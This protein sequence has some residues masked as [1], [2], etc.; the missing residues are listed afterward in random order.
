MAQIDDV[1]EQL[2]E[3]TA[4]FN[5]FIKN[6][7]SITEFTEQNPPEDAT[8]IAGT[9]NGNN[10]KLSVG[11]LKPNYTAGTNIEI[12]NDVISTVNSPS[13]DYTDLNVLLNPPEYKAGRKWFDGKNWNYYDNIPGTSLQLAKEMVLPVR[14][15]NG[16]LLSNLT[17]VKYGEAIG[18]VVSVVRAQADTVANCAN[19]ALVTNDIIVGGEGKA[20]YIG[21]AKGDTSA[22][23]V[24]DRLFVSATNA[25]ELTNVEQPILSYVGVVLVSDAVDGVILVN[26]SG[27]INITAIGQST[28]LNTSQ[29]LTTTPVPLEGYNNNALEL[30]TVVTHTGTTNLTTQISPASIGASG[31]YKN[32]FKIAMSSTSNNRFIFELYKNAIPTGFKAVV[33][34][35]NNNIDSGGD[36]IMIYSQTPILET[37]VLEIYAYSDG[38]G[39]ANIDSVSFSISRAGVV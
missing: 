10:V 6:S 19:V 16:A 2:N 4:M 13:F 36:S 26:P 3:L 11:N 33:D 29:A 20:C 23:N 27:I 15:D 24:N 22:W 25:G 31:Y 30:N 8:E 14:N 35:S 17:V 12:E 38:N 39:T 28:G 34:L 32:D 37:D 5:S 1:T 21:E 18:G 9:Y 7:Q